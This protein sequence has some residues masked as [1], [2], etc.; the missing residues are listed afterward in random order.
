MAR[1]SDA[2]NFLKA[3]ILKEKIT[4]FSMKRLYY[5]EQAIEY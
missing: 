3:K 5:V 2:I 4:R 1:I